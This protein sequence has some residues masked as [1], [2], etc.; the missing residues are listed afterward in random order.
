MNFKEK[1]FYYKKS[2]LNLKKM[3]GGNLNDIQLNKDQLDKFSDEE[4][5]YLQDDFMND[6]KKKYPV[7]RYDNARSNPKYLMKNI[8]YGEMNYEGM[9]ILIE[10]IHTVHKLTFTHFL[11]IGSGNGKLPLQVAALSNVTKSIGIELV[12]ERHATAIKIKDELNYYKKI[13]DKVLFI[14]DEFNNV[15]LVDYI[16]DITLV[17][18]SN[19]CFTIE[20]TN[21]IF[22]EL[23]NIL[24][25]GSIISCSEK[26][27]NI[28]ID[29]PKKLNIIDNISVPMSWNT[30][31]N[32]YIYKIE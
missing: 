8:T 17:W 6:L 1:Y 10:H 5:I 14:N 12:E 31:S 7:T 2:Y 30:N 4:I 29:T 13:I 18:I 28:F 20:L 26:Y 25:K 22:N 3:L 19:K 23:L 9:D 27:S 15:K 24:P 21:K 16:N 11:D 32:I